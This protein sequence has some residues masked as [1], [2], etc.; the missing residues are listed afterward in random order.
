MWR[1]TFLFLL[2]TWGS[3]HVLAG[4]A[5]IR[6][7]VSPAIL[8]DEHGMLGDFRRYLSA[9]TGREFEVIPRG[10]YRETFDLMRQEKLDFAWVSA[11]PYLYLQRTLKAR[12]LVVPLFHGRPSIRAYLI[13]PAGATITSGL[14]DLEGKLFA[15]A[16][17]DS[18]TGHYLPRYELRQA[19]KDSSSFFA[20]T[21][22]ARGQRNVVRAVASGLADGAYVHDFSWDAL[23]ESEPELTATVRIAAR[24]PEY[25][26][27]PLIARA[28]ASEVDAK[29]LSRTLLE[30][31]S[32][33]EGAELLK[34]M[35]I[36]GFAVSDPK[37]YED[38]DK[39]MRAMGQP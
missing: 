16:D 14:L 6:I 36:D 33:A 5:P 32:D 28:G 9:R 1:V 12:L 10:S 8:Q 17:P 25:G 19:G 38:V 20:K 31:A 11:Y 26:A 34:R 37:A 30:M 23:V 39:I 18:F 4:G 13:V 15:Y 2:V 35:H 3:G 21:F 29:L 22:F 7:G 27:P 24:S